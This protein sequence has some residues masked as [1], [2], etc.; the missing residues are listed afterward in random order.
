ME[1]IKN[2]L[3]EELFN[4]VKSKIGD[5]ELAI[6]NDGS[7]I[8]K[9]KFD[10]K[11][12]EIKLLKDKIMAGEAKNADVEK[13]LKS[14]TDLE[15]KYNDLNSKYLADLDSK[16]KEI[17]NITKKS[18]L[19]K[20]LKENGAIYEDLLMSQ[21]NLDTIEIDGDKLKNFDVKPLQE[22]YGSMFEAKQ[23]TGASTQASTQNSLGDQNVGKSALIQQ[24]NEAEKKRDFISMLSLSNQIKKF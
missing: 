9:S 21:I 18:L 17:S 23:T 20:A 8:P 10:D 15:T 12:A 3:G 6:T 13:L 16:N 5:K 7:W 2:L 4:Q 1:N 19:S 22:K 24:Y 11:L 14:N